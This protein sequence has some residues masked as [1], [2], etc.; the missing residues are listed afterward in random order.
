MGKK[1]LIY[2]NILGFKKKAA[3]IAE[4][5]GLRLQEIKKFLN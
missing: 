2:L 1:Y 5:T 4:K 3:G